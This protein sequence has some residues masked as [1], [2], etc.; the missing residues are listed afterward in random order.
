MKSLI[1][2]A[3]L[4]ALCFTQAGTSAEVP[5]TPGSMDPFTLTSSA[6][7]LHEQRQ[8]GPRADDFQKSFPAATIDPATMR[9]VQATAAFQIQD[10]PLLWFSADRT[11]A[12]LDARYFE[13]LT[14]AD[15]T[16]ISSGQK[17][18]LG[19]IK[20]AAR[21]LPPAT[22]AR[23]LMTSGIILTFAHIESTLRLEKETTS[24]EGRYEARFTGSHLFFTNE[25]NERPLAFLVVIEP[26][27]TL[28]LEGAR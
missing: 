3:F 26:D 14:Q 5:S 21:V 19:K 10:Q 13:A 17:L 16:R 18:T 1:I 2:P 9:A 25:R 20:P 8:L 4:F 27:G 7:V 6:S 28:V 24:S 23:F 12:V 22:L 11:R 15:A